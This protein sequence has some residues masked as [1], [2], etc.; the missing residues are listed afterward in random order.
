MLLRLARKALG[1][2]VRREVLSLGHERE[3][4]TGANTGGAKVMP[5]LKYLPDIVATLRRHNLPAADVERY[6]ARCLALS[7]PCNTLPCPYC[8][9]NGRLTQD[10]TTVRSDP[11]RQRLLCTTCQREFD[12]AG[13]AR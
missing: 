11:G 4:L 8:Y 10:L 3:R 1:A 2:S 5:A 6:Q 13:A 9:L 7:Q 12:V